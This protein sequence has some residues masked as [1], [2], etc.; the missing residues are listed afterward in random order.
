MSTIVLRARIPAG[1]VMLLAFLSGC[2]G[3]RLPPMANP[4]EARTALASALD[5]WK[6]GETRESL[7]QRTPPI[8]FNDDKWQPTTL[9][10]DYAILEEHEV[11]GQSVRLTVRLTFKKA[12][13][14]KVDRPVPYLIDTAPAIVI[15]PG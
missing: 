7:T 4:D 13:G 6:K 12:D 14:R 8:Y 5:A 10:L 2:G 1:M 15:V 3:Q 9:L 11:Y